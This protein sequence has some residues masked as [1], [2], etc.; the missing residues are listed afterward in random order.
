[1][2]IN[3]FADPQYKRCQT[4]GSDD[5]CWTDTWIENFELFD[6]AVDQAID[7]AREAVNGS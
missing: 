1:M 5:S 3:G 7:L 6:Y 2:S 4:T